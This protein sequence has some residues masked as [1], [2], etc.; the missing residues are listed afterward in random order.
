M[1]NSLEPWI[2]FKV[3]KKSANLSDITHICLLMGFT[4]P[5]KLRQISWLKVSSEQYRVS[6]VVVIAV[7]PETLKFGEIDAMFI[8]DSQKAILK[9][10]P[11]KTNGFDN[12]YYA[13]CVQQSDESYVHL[14]LSKISHPY[15]C[16][17][18]ATSYFSIPQ[19]H[20]VLSR[21]I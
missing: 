9:C 10:K 8:Y 3:Q 16:N 15:V 11:L 20:V 19:Y 4:D 17:S 18:C 13:Y 5:S 14:D 2:K 12:H 21:P 7:E 1:K 6:S